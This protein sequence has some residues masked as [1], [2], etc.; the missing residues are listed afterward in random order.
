MFNDKVYFESVNGKQI[1]CTFSESETPARKLVIMS[2]GFRGSNIGP[3]RQF[4]DFQRILNKNGYSVLRIDQPNCGNSEGD[5]LDSSFRE[6]V[7]TLVYFADKYL[8]AGFEVNLLGQ[9][10]GA[11]AVIVAS[12]SSQ[13]KGK[14][15]CLLLWVPDPETDFTGDTQKIYEEGGQKYRGLFWQEAKD[16]DIY[17]CLTDYVGKIHL[18]YGE[19][20]KYVKRKLVNKTLKIVEAKGQSTLILPGQ[21]HSPWEFDLVQEVYRRE[22]IKLQE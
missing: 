2:H 22:L 5:Y 9:S 8:K 18:V 17:Q 6:W 1:F 20:D 16:S 15:P 10:M 11:S 19:K 4:V 12:S 7:N 13:L 21:D 14:I 3:A